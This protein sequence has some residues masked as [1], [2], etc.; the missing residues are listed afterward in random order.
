[1]LKKIYIFNKFPTQLNKIFFLKKC[2]LFF[3]IKVNNP[4]YCKKLLI[5]FFIKINSCIEFVKNRIKL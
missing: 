5:L 4:L 2:I 1:M 3:S